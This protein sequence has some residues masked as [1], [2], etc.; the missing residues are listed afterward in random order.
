MHYLGIDVSKASLEVSDVGGD[1]RRNFKNTAAGI[2]GLL[3]WTERHFGGQAH[4]ILEP[5]SRYHHRVVDLLDRGGVAHTVINPYRTKAWGILAGKR[6]KTD[7]VDAELL[8]RLG[9]SERPEP[10]DPVDRS[11]ERLKSLRRHR[12]QLEGELGAARNR[13]EAAE[14]SPWTDPA[15]IESL[16]R[17]IAHLKDEIAAAGRKLDEAVEGDELLSSLV[18]LLETVPGVGRRTALLLLSELPPAW[19]CRH[20]RAWVAFAGLCPEPR[21]SGRGSWSR[22]SRAG[23][24]RIRKQLFMATLAAMRYN[25]AVSAYVARLAGRGK[26]GKLAVIAAMA[27]LVRICFGVLRTRRP[28]DPQM[29]LRQTSQTP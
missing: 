20:R 13:L 15:V 8:A 17:V 1:R 10:S 25:P 2:G 3:A 9:E 14:H 11:Q 24:G 5:T 7:K 23:S 21:Q 16:R 26:T 4:V 28:F 18:G 22:L 6:A 27:M 12:E 19:S 29:H